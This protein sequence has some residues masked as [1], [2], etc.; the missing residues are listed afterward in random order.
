MKLMSQYL[1]FDYNYVGHCSSIIL[2][3]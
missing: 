1:E 2:A 3:S